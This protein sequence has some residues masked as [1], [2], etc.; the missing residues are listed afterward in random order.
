MSDERRQ[1]EELRVARLVL[2]HMQRHPGAKDT[3]EGIARWWLHMQRIDRTVDTVLRA[4][5]VLKSRRLAV[6]RRAL[7]GR[8]YYSLNTGRLDDVSKFLESM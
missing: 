2:A 4:L 5:E 8:T 1:S 3:A 7:D 6:E